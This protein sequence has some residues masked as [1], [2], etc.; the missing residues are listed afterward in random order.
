MNLSIHS[1]ETM[2][3]AVTLVIGLVS[4]TVYAQSAHAFNLDHINCVGVANG[5]A[6]IDTNVDGT[7]GP[8]GE[9]G[10]FGFDGV[11][12]F[13]VANGCATVDTNTPGIHGIH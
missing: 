6:S 2:L 12:C 10:L 13:G 5:C 8:R 4:A 11:N 9:H 1:K 7:H 3:V